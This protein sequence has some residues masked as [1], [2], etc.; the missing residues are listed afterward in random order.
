MIVILVVG[1][2]LMLVGCA[3]VTVVGCCRVIVV[4]CNL[5]TVVDSVFIMVDC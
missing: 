2:D 1:D 5:N 3:C 4:G